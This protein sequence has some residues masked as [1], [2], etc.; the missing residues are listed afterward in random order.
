MFGALRSRDF[1]LFWSGA[2]VSNIG[3][4]IQ[5][6]ALS[7]LVL[8][9]TN[10]PF[11]LG[12]VSFAGTAPIL[13]LSLFGG[14]FV[15]RTDRRR[16]LIFTQT[17]LLVLAVALAGFTY[18]KTVGIGHIVVISLLTGIVLAANGP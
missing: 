5:S 3:S 6:I 13:A 16:L 18:A 8:Q 7:W 15:D 9:L 2:F 1:R 10:S 12:V 11:A 4:W 14:V 17:L